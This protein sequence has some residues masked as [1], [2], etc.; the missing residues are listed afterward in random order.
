MGTGKFNAGG[1]PAKVVRP[2]IFMLL[3]PDITA[4]V[5]SHLA[6]LHESCSFNNI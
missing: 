6:P 4:G 1:N 3:K 5:V 2:S